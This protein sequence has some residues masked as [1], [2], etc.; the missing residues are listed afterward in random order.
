MNALE[1][2]KTHPLYL[3]LSECDRQQVDSWNAQPSG[4]DNC[5][6]C[7]GKRVLC[8]TPTLCTPCDCK[9]H[10]DNARAMAASGLTERLKSMTF[11]NFLV[12][13]P[14]QK[15]MKNLA[16][17]YLQEN[18]GRWFYASGQVGSGKTHI[19]TAIVAEL[20]N[21]GHRARYMVWPDEVDGIKGNADGFAG[22]LEKL[23]AAPVLYI[24]DFLKSPGSRSRAGQAAPTDAE[25]QA[26]FKIINR[27][28][29]RSDQVTLFSSEW[30]LSEVTAFDEGLGSRISER[31]GFYRLEIARKTERNQRFEN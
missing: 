12:K 31:A 3:E 4:P 23:M 14:W 30:F 2:I 11:S 29:N 26:A 1:R 21:S 16:Q 25:V 7:H 20:I 13:H 27:R 28:Y 18:K 10:H 24:D 15:D 17:R 9:A 22:R 5:P 19:C 6:L 8:I